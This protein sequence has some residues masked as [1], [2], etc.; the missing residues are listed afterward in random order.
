MKTVITPIGTS[1]ISNYVDDF[2]AE[3]ESR[4]INQDIRAVYNDTRNKSNRR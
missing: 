2:L 4:E 3:K 1:L